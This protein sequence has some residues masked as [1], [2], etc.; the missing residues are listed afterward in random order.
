[1]PYGL[2]FLSPAAVQHR[3]I[4][5]ASSSG[6]LGISFMVLVLV[7]RQMCRCSRNDLPA[8]PIFHLRTVRVERQS[9]GGLRLV[10]SYFQAVGVYEF[11]QCSIPVAVCNSAASLQAWA[12]LAHFRTRTHPFSVS[13]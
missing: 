2:S 13:L 7:R 4:S 10:R 3:R 12:K 8:H 9:G 1:M 6:V 11:T 5:A